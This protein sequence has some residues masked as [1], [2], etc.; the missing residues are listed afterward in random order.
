[1]MD[2]ILKNAMEVI[3]SD[4]FENIIMA[5]TITKEIMLAMASAEHGSTD[6]SD[7]KTDEFM[8]IND[9][10]MALYAK[11]LDIDGPREVLTSRLKN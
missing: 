3:K 5:K 2:F 8:A 4:S 10:R 6:S 9:L 7:K 1:M 11:G